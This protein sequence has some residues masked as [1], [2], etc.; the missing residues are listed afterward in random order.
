[1]PIILNSP[2]NKTLQ[3]NLFVPSQNLQI[4]PAAA[5][6]FAPL[7]LDFSN[8]NNPVPL[9]L[10]TPAYNLNFDSFSSLQ[11]IQSIEFDT[12]QMLV[13]LIVTIS[14]VLS[15]SVN[16]PPGGFFRM[17]VPATSPKILLVSVG[18]TANPEAPASGDY[19]VALCWVKNF[20][21][22]P[23]NTTRPAVRM[24]TSL[25][26]AGQMIFYDNHGN[27]PPPRLR[28][29]IYSVAAQGVIAGVAVVNVN[30][31]H[32]GPQYLMNVQ[33]ELNITA[34][35][36]YTPPTVISGLDIPLPA[37]VA[38][39]PANVGEPVTYTL[40][41]IDTPPGGTTTWLK[42]LVETDLLTTGSAV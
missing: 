35:P 3:P 11:S 13:S 24:Y 17:N 15:Q 41:F 6:G 26:A 36:G 30:D 25:T 10:A 31:G 18:P 37:D 19:G 2:D 33:A 8:P 7:V 16:V 27:S 39:T 42:L 40:N 4:P 34:S 32:A 23:I 22:E 21:D 5:M 28:G 38:V 20:I 29:L 1:M 14:G 12:R 9:A